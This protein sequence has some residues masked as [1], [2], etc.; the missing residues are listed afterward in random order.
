MKQHAML[1]DLKKA[2]IRFT[3]IWSGQHQ[4]I[5]KVGGNHPTWEGSEISFGMA[6]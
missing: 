3:Y 5:R 6:V 1:E 4:A 2:Q